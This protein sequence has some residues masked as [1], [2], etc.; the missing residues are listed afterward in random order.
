MS[1]DFENL[2]ISTFIVVASVKLLNMAEFDRW[3]KEHYTGDAKSALVSDELVRKLLTNNNSIV[4]RDDYAP[5]D[6]LIAP[7]FEERF[8]YSRK[9]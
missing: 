8:G 4:I 2:R 6:N 1:P 3:L 9:N 5:V 7:V